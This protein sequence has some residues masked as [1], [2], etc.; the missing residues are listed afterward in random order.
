MK[1]KGN[2]IIISAPSGSGKTTIEK[3]VVEEV[4]GIKRSI[5]CTTRKL[6]EG[7]EQSEDYVFISREEFSKKI[8]D[9]YFLEWEENFGSYYGTPKEQFIKAQ[10]QGIDI[11]LSIDVKGGKKVKEIF[12]ESISIFIMPPSV[13]ELENRLRKRKTDTESQLETRLKE[14]RNEMKAQEEYEYLVINEYLE[15]AVNE[16]KAIILKERE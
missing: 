5:S 6:R 13:K 1:N 8:E 15:K 14:A 7:E 9:K 3:R 11:L 16:V 4:P 12:P 2:I 10:A